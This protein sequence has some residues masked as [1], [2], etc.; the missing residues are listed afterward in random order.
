MG[1]AKVYNSNKI[2]LPTHHLRHQQLES[3]ST[4]SSLVVSSSS[5]MSQHRTPKT[6][7]PRRLQTSTS[8]AHHPTSNASQDLHRR[9]DLLHR[10]WR[11]TEG[12]SSLMIRWP[13]NRTSTRS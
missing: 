8:A 10:Q 12:R 5:T 11:H 9:K 4:R 2:E 1:R 13:Q 7:T 3:S 6:T